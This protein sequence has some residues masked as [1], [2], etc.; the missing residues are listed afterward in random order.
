LNDGF[1]D[2]STL[3]TAP[4]PD[5]V[6]VFASRRS[7]DGALTVAVVNKN[8]Y[9]PSNPGATTQITVDLSHFAGTGTAQFWR[10]AATNPSNQTVA[11]ITQQSPLTIDANNSFT[12]NAAMQSVNLFVIMPANQPAPTVQSAQVGDG[13]AQRSS[14]SS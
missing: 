4:N 6:S 8:L 3:A 7:S 9:D 14:V 1:G 11:T 12:F 10:L 5:Q 13:S 2:V